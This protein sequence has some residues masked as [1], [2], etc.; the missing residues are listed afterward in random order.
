MNKAKTITLE[1]AQQ[2][3]AK[4]LNNK[5]WNLLQKED[6]TAADNERMIHAAHA[7]CY[8]WLNAGTGLHHQR[9]EWLIAHV[10]AHLGLPHAALRHADRCLELT[11]EFADL[12]QDFDW[13]YGYEGVA[14]ANALAGN[15]EN[16]RIYIQRAR[17]AGEAIVD[18]EDGRIFF[19]D[20]AWAGFNN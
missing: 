13:A 5:V 19:G 16:A 2:Q 14:R 8:H 6:R 9:A 3:F 12:M 4:Q 10:Y 17:E 7:S 1:E 11:N 15:E 18:D 20:F